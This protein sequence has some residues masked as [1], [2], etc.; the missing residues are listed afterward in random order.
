MLSRTS[1]KLLF[2]LLTM[3]VGF[4]SLTFSLFKH[5]EASEYHI[6]TL[7]FGSLLPV[8]NL[9]ELLLTLQRDVALKLYETH[10]SGKSSQYLDLI[11]KKSDKKIMQLWQDYATKYKSNKE[12]AFVSHVD[13]KMQTLHH[14]IL[15]LAINPDFLRSKK[16]PDTFITLSQ[17]VAV[18]NQLISKLITY[19]LELASASRKDHR[20]RYKT[21]RT[22]LFSTI[23]FVLLLLLL[24]FIPIS[25]SIKKT[26]AKLHQ[27]ATDLE[28]A[29]K[30]LHKVSITDGLTGLYNRRYFDQIFDNEIS[31]AHRKGQALSFMMLDIDHFKKYN[32]YYGHPAGDDVIKKVAK[33]LSV[34]FKRPGDLIFRLG[35]EEFGI[36]TTDTTKETVVTMAEELIAGMFEVNVAHIKSSTKSYVTLS[37]GLMHYEKAIEIASDKLYEAADKQLYEA[38][39]S[40]RNKV[41]YEA[42]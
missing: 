5:Q 24:L 21:E 38:K 25:N 20:S 12:K 3:L 26:E 4:G 8:S 6:K 16:A 29:N 1:S 13:L 9:K 37:M 23:G 7:Y 40:G 2:L 17:G 35:G 36:I 28:R 10:V 31:R 39:E 18:I 33:H 34:S 30:D 14:Y 22:I 32:D 11:L 19:E 27:A 41:V 42:V 15:Q